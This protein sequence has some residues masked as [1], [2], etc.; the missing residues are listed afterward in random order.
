MRSPDGSLIN[1]R[2]NACN[3]RSCVLAAPDRQTVHLLC[4]DPAHRERLSHRIGTSLHLTSCP[5]QALAFLQSGSCHEVIVD[6]C[7]TRL[8][9]CREPLSGLLARAR[10][11]MTHKTTAFMQQHTTDSPLSANAHTTQGGDISIGNHPL[12]K[13]PA[14]RITLGQLSSLFGLSPRQL[15]RLF[16]QSGYESPI[17]EF[18]RRHLTQARELILCS[19]DSLETIAERLG[20]SDGASFSRSF[21]RIFGYS[22]S[23]LRRPHRTL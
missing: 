23:R 8:S 15:T 17:T 16:A 2:S 21:K 19:H 1:R 7:A 5:L 6:R 9:C 22:P 12:M 20:Y 14:A 13:A 10:L 4:L 11:T 3:E 18:R